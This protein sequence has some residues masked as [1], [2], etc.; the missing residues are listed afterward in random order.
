MIDHLRRT[1]K[2]LVDTAP[3]VVQ[4]TD[5]ANANHGYH[6]IIRGKQERPLKFI[7]IIL[8]ITVPSEPYI[9]IKT[10]VIR[11]PQKLSVKG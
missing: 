4:F 5:M 11:D 6:G 8:R 1:Q 2:G 9:T 7:S 10:K 3:C